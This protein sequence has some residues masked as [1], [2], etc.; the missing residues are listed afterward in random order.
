MTKRQMRNSLNKVGDGAELSQALSRF[1]VHLHSRALR[2]T[3]E[4][5]AIARAALER[6]SHF[7]VEE[8]TTDV[9]ARGVDASRATVYRT[10]PLLL[11]AGNGTR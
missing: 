11:E 10:L 7:T 4:R 2:M 1:E 8:L 9:Q 6:G 5:E 3:G